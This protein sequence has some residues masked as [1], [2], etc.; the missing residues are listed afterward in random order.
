MSNTSL[1][2][3]ALQAAI[4]DPHK[5]KEVDYSYESFYE[6]FLQFNS[7]VKRKSVQKAEQLVV[8]KRSSL[9]KGMLGVLWVI[10]MG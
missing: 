9:F 5:L 4:Q 8:V 1:V 7:K 6:S 10:I 3:E 2:L